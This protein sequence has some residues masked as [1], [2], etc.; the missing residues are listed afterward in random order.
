MTEQ[1]KYYMVIIDEY[2]FGAEI[3]WRTERQGLF[4]SYREASEWLIDEGFELYADK[5]DWIDEL[6]YHLYFEIPSYL[7]SESYIAYIEEW[8]VLD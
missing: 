4:K 2:S 1:L 5:M 7:G 8:K 6:T 3:P